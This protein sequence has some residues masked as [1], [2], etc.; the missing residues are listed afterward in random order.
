MKFL[1]E[2]PGI[3]TITK[4]SVADPPTVRLY[5]VVLTVVH[6]VPVYLIWTVTLKPA[7]ITV[8]EVGVKK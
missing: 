4:N 5:E 6:E 2:S 8:P 7:T 3:Y 1:D